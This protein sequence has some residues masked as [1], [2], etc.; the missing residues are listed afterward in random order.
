M[1]WRLLRMGWS[2]PALQ[3][4][5]R[6]GASGVIFR[7]VKREYQL[8]RAVLLTLAQDDPSM[9]DEVD[10]PASLP[11][12]P[13]HLPSPFVV[14][15]VVGLAASSGNATLVKL[16]DGTVLGRLKLTYTG[17]T[18]AYVVSNGALQIEYRRDD[19]TIWQRAPEAAGNSTEAYLM[20]LAEGHVFVVRARWRNALGANS[21]WRAATMLHTGKSA[22]PSDVA[23]LTAMAVP[24]GLR[25]AWSKCPDLDYR[26]TELLVSDTLLL[27][28][29]VTVWTGAA[30]EHTWPEA[31][32]GTH[33]KAWVRHL[34][35]SGKLSFASSPA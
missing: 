34:D 7:V 21:D 25:Y 1:W 16:E 13:A 10:A 26:D 17:S 29:A 20:E 2:A 32:D 5:C 35:T 9:Y 11:S 27:A 8:G 3:R 6:R 22:P 24:G 12:P 33:Y 4:P 23:D 19:G 28:D 15:P 31:L 14:A 30:S 18:D